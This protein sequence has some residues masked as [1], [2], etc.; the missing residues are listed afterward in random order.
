MNNIV[1]LM[2]LGE[3]SDEYGNITEKITATRDVFEGIKSIGM[4]EHNAASERGL[5]PF[6]VLEVHDFEYFGEKVVRVNGEVY[7]VYR[8]YVRQNDG[9]CELYTSR[10]DISLEGVK[11]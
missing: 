10:R 9:I 11:E 7:D 8:T 5:K 6:G 4:N 2:T 3:V 1:T